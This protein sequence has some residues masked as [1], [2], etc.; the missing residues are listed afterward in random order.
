MHLHFRSSLGNWCR[1][2]KRKEFPIF[3]FLIRFGIF[4]AFSFLS[5]SLSMRARRYHFASVEFT[6]NAMPKD[7]DRATYSTY[8]SKNQQQQQQ[9]KHMRREQMRKN[10][11]ESNVATEMGFW[12]RIEAAT[13]IAYRFARKFKSMNNIKYCVV[14]F[15]FV[16]ARSPFYNDRCASLCL[17]YFSHC[18][19]VRLVQFQQTRA[20]THT[21]TGE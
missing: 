1:V 13:A 4:L 17:S 12:E 21:H 7:E 10:E 15:D 11:T 19:A 14:N 8:Q 9:R 3:L 16:C 6:V 5:F 20:D 2:E 18:R